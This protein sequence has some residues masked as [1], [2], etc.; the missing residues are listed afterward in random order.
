[1]DIKRIQTFLNGINI[2]NN[3]EWFQEHKTEYDIVRADFEQ[4]V[5]KLITAISKFDLEIA[6]LVP[7]D[8]TYRFY[9]DIRFSPDKSPYKRHLGAYICAKGRKSLRGGYYFHLQPG[10]NIIAVGCYYLPTNILTSC[11]NE[12]IVNIEEW[13]K[14]VENNNFVSTFGKVG[15]G[16]W[17]GKN[18]ASD[19]G[20]GLDFLKTCPKG[21]PKDYQYIKYLRMKDYCCWLKLTDDFFLQPN[22]EDQL[23]NICKVGKP[24]MDM[25][26]SV[27]DDYE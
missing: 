12:I 26:N 4:S 24:M 17:D 15:E 25:I 3:R 19:K 23:A 5:F 2:N 18:T 11:R 6:H 20:F 27:V 14:N 21:F 7:K 10:N 9:R 16:K 1:M 13:L 22:W 8:C